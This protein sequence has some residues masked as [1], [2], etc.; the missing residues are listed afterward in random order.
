MIST[1]KSDWANQLELRRHRL[2]MSKAAVAKRSGVPRATVDRILSG[3]EKSPRISSLRAIAKA[4]GV[5]V[6]LRE[7][8]SAQQFRKAQAIAKAKRVAGLVQGTM[9]L[10][11]QAVDQHALDEMVD[12][13]ASELLAGSPRRLWDD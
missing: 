8:M 7:T 2:R 11:S 12:Q 3:N 4:L 9:G 5:E 10:E 1:A 6:E 13:T